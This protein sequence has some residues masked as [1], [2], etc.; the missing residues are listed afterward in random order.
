MKRMTVTIRDKLRLNFVLFKIVHDIPNSY[1]NL[2]INYFVPQISKLSPWIKQ[3]SFW[4]M[5]MH[6]SERRIR[7]MHTLSLCDE[8]SLLSV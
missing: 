7:E 8:I 4:S 3:S 2:Q 1:F 6:Y 5:N